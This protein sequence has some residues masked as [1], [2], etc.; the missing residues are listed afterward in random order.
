MLRYAVNLLLKIR[1]LLA[2]QNELDPADEGGQAGSAQL[3]YS[4]P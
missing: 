4:A 3:S 1:P 2:V